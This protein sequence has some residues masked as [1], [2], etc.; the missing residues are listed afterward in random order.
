MRGILVDFHQ[1]ITVLVHCSCYHL[2]WAHITARQNTS[3]AKERLVD[4]TFA[5]NNLRRGVQNLEKTSTI[6][7]QHDVI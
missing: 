7:E 4:L 3:P 2:M 5:W 6:E 1:I